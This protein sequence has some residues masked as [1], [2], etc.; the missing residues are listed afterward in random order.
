[1]DKDKQYISVKKIFLQQLVEASSVYRDHIN[2]E[3]IT[4]VLQKKFIDYLS[5]N[6]DNRETSKYLKYGEAKKEYGPDMQGIVFEIDKTQYALS[7]I[8]YSAAESEIPDATKKQFK[9]LKQEDWE[10]SLRIAWAILKSLEWNKLDD[11]K[12]IKNWVDSIS[13]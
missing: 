6:F 5:D 12:H 1:M 10:L 9:N 7:D 2:Q 8:V 13:K 3:K 11:P 4:K